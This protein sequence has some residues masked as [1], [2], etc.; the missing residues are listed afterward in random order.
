MYI[1]P[2]M[3]VLSHLV[4]MRL[5]AVFAPPALVELAFGEFPP[6]FKAAFHIYLKEHF[7]VQGRECLSEFLSCRG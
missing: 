7:I 2:A 3:A 4:A 1:T 5:G 6:A